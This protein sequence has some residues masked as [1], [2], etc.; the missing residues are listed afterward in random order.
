LTPFWKKTFSF[1]SGML[2][3]STR[4]ERHPFDSS[5]VLKIRPPLGRHRST[6]ALNGGPRLLMRVACDP[7]RLGLRDSGAPPNG[8]DYRRIDHGFL[9]G[10][11]KVPFIV[12]R[13][14][15]HHAADDL[16]R[17]CSRVVSVPR[18]WRSAPPAAASRA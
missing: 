14:R 3:L 4:R 6:A 1:L 7:R 16:L 15:C 17:P 13:W 2:P 12:A 10:T 5:P 18:W 11:C 8:F 9:G